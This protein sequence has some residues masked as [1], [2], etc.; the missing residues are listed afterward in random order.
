MPSRAL[1][2]TLSSG[3]TH[4]E[5]PLFDAQKTH[6]GSSSLILAAAGLLERVERGFGGNIRHAWCG[7]SSHS[8]CRFHRPGVGTGRLPKLQSDQEINYTRWLP[9]AWGI[10]SKKSVFLSE[11]D[12]KHRSMFPVRVTGKRVGPLGRRHANPFVR[13]GNHALRKAQP[14]HALHP[15]SPGVLWPVT[16]PRPGIREEE[17]VNAPPPCPFAPTDSPEEAKLLAT[18]QPSGSWIRKNSGTAQLV[19]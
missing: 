14:Q 16:P 2:S 15:I 13:G 3:Y 17:L 1:T 11:S 18:L 6:T 19:A 5:A 7:F 8:C 10:I 4:G 12:Q 9:G